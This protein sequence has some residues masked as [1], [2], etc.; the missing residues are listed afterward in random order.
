MRGCIFFIIIITFLLIKIYKGRECIFI[1]PFH[2]D[3]PN[4]I[5]VNYLPLEEFISV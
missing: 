1:H 5:Q 2:S 3:T 4:K